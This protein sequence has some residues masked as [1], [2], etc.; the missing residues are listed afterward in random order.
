MVLTIFRWS[1]SL[2]RIIINFKVQNR[3]RAV[4]NFSEMFPDL[5]VQMFLDLKLREMLAE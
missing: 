3:F 1:R 5:L 2:L 4:N